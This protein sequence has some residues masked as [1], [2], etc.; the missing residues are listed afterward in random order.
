MPADIQT[1]LGDF[2]F[3]ERVHSVN[4]ENNKIIVNFFSDNISLSTKTQLEKII[5]EC[6]LPTHTE[7]VVFFERK[8]KTI[9]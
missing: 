7:V 5:R 8:E 9:L 1:Q 6:L 4:Q 3:Q 2:S